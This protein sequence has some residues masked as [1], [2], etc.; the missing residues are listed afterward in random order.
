MNA[1][2]PATEIQPELR[3]AL[4]GMGR[5]KRNGKNNPSVGFDDDK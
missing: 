5:D 3:L 1:F 2:P 4:R